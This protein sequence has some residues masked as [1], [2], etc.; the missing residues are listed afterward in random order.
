MRIVFLCLLMCCEVAA[1]QSVI[2]PVGFR[3]GRMMSAL[4]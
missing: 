4:L 3:F 1:A 2:R